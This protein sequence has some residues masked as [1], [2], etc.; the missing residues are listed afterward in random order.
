MPTTTG[1]FGVDWEEFHQG[2]QESWAEQ[3]VA[4]SRG[5]LVARANAVRFL[6]DM[7]GWNRIEAGMLRRTLPEEHPVYKKL[8]VAEAQLVE[9]YGRMD[10][11]GPGASIRYDYY[12]YRIN[13]A[14]R[15]YE[16]LTDNQALASPLKELTRFVE[17]SWSYA[18]E[19]VTLPAKSFKWSDSGK[20]LMAAQT[21][22][23]GTKELTYIW[24]LVPMVPDGNIQDAL[25]KVNSQPFD[26][27]DP[28]QLLFLAPEVIRIPLAPA[29]GKPIWNIA[30][31]FMYRKAGW[32]KFYRQSGP[33]GPGFYAVDSNGDGTGVKPFEGYDLNNLFVVS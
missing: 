6:V 15:P 24:H 3:S 29:D 16:L 14:P 26:G 28:E 33:S 7:L 19:N 11:Q 22:P 30:Y 31:K 32:N 1:T 10:D 21:K 5:A 23:L 9:P 20:S 25:G 4:V 2:W 18:V 12:L 8:Y 17:R 13:Y 27:Y